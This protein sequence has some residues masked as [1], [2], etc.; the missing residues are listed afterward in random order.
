MHERTHQDGHSLVRARGSRSMKRAAPRPM[1]TARSGFSLIELL[2]VI[3]V[4]VLLVSILLPSLQRAR[5]DA[6]RTVCLANLK[7]LGA[8]MFTYSS[9]NRENGPQ[10]VPLVVGGVPVG[11]QGRT[12]PRNLLSTAGQMVNLGLLWPRMI[13]EPQ[14]F[15]C[16]SQRKFLAGSNPRRFLKETVVGSYAY[17]VHIPSGQ[18]PRLSAIRHLAM[19]TDD[20]VSGSDHEG[21]GRYS[22]AVGYNVL[23]TDGSA[24]WYANP[25]GSIWKK[26]VYWDDETDDVTYDAL[27][28]N[29]AGYSSSTYYYPGTYDKYDLFRVWRSFCYHRPDPF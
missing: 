14:E 5:E 23:Y 4:I 13:G 26:A 27:Y 2:V 25:S 18:S 11:Y 24:Y 21:I 1:G 28:K 12:A 19:A 17:A 8:G 3:A 16:P 9:V 7:H 20:F 29:G 22:H 15:F 6:R 10:V